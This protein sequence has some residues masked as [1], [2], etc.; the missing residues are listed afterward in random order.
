MKRTYKIREATLTLEF[1]DI[2]KSSAEVI[3][4]SDDHL[5]GMYGGVSGDLLGAA[6][7][8][9]RVDAAKHV[10]ARLGDVVVT[11]AGS[12]PAKYV[13]HA[14]TVGPG[15]SSPVEVIRKT[16]R[17]SLLLLE[18][19]DLSTIA[20]PAIGAGRASFSYDDVAVE[21]ADAITDALGQSTR[22]LQITIYLHDRFHRMQ[23][24]DFVRFFEELATRSRLTAVP[25]PGQRPRAPWKK[26]AERSTAPLV[27]LSYAEDE[28]DEEWARLLL[29]QLSVLERSGAISLWHRGMID[30]GAERDAVIRSHLLRASAVLVLVS[31]DHNGSPSCQAELEVALEQ[32]ATGRTLV[33]PILIRPVADVH[34]ELRA[35]QPLPRNGKSAAEWSS[36]DAAMVD[37]VEGFKEALSTRSSGGA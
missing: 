1:G 26:L 6:G 18:A 5:L 25:A 24:M 23:E 14:V 36:K 7:P 2:T 22:A 32:Q 3:V 16:T 33:I 30:A 8:A 12:L 13:F 20:F 21:M 34:G 17:R 35:L 15:E 31:P 27:F 11:T 37:V 10:P 28:A 9:L 19:L 29:Q 4:S